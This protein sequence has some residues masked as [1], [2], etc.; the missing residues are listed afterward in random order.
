VPKAKRKVQRQKEPHKIRVIF[1]DNVRQIM[2]KKYGSSGGAMRKLS[3]AAHVSLSTIQRLLDCSTGATID[4]V[5]RI[6]EVLGVRSSDLMTPK[7]GEHH[8][9]TTTRHAPAERLHA[10]PTPPPTAR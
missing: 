10:V 5:A 1:A 9:G 8:D 2:E 3:L 4:T 6:G 7:F